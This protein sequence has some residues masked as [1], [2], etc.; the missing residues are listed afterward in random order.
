VEMPIKQ[1]INFK[2]GE[3]SKGLHGNIF[4][5]NIVPFFL[6]GGETLWIYV[7]HHRLKKRDLDFN[8]FSFFVRVYD[9]KKW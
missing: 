5:G 6:L 1:K 7:P 2:S 8:L 9:D 3:V 4:I